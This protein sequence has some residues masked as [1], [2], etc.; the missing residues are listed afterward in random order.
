MDRGHV[1]QNFD[2]GRRVCLSGR[3][4]LGSGNTTFHLN[5]GSTDTAG[6]QAGGVRYAQGW[7]R[8]TATLT[9]G[10]WHFVVMTCNAGTKASYVDGALDAWT[11]G[12]DQWSAS[13]TGGQFWIGGTPNTGDGNVALNGLIDEVMSMTVR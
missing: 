13:G 7:E 5:N 3:W 8:G 1:D 12:Q 10:A 6:S 11:S 4:R 9:D 2:G